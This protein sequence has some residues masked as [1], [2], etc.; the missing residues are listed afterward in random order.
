MTVALKLEQA[1]REK[2]VYFVTQYVPK[3]VVEYVRAYASFGFLLEK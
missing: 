1:N 2:S 3:M